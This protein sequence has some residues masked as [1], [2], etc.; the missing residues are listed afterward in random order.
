MIQGC[1]LYPNQNPKDNAGPKA[2]NARRKY[3]EEMAIKQVDKQFT[4]Y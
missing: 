1:R 4:N 2:W 3:P